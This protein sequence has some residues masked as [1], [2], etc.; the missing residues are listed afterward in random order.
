MSRASSWSFGEQDAA[1]ITAVLQDF[2]QQSNAGAALLVD[3]AGQM[4]ASVG[5]VPDFDPMAFASLTAADFSANDQLA[6]MVGESE[7][8][9]LVHQG[10]QESL[11]LAD[12][13]GRVILVVIFDRGTTL[14]LV[15]LR[16]KGAVGQ[17][18]EIFAAI[19]AAE[20]TD[21]PAVEAE[22]LG[23]AEDEIDRLFGG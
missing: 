2:L 17:L 13:A 19:M 7:F 14:G 8:G 18:N 1:R 23:D 15:K 4:V 5:Q 10:Q 9:A 20:A 3:R 6:R 22:F 12:V 21:E 11:Y 16:A